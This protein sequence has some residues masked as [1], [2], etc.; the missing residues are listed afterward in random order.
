MPRCSGSA[1]AEHPTVR[2]DH[3]EAVEIGL[4]G[5][6]EIAEWQHDAELGGEPCKIRDKW[7]A[8]EGMGEREEFVDQHQVRSLLLGLPH[9]PFGM[10][11][12]L[13]EIENVAKFFGRD[14]SA[15]RGA[16]RCPW[17]L[18]PMALG[19]LRPT[20]GEVRYKGVSLARLSSSAFRDFRR[21]VQ[22]VFQNPFETFNPFYRVSHALELALRLRGVSPSSA[23]GKA[24]MDEALARVQLDPAQVLHRYSHELS[25]GQ[26]QRI[27]IARAI[28]VSPKLIVADEAVSMVDASLRVLILRYLL[29]LRTSSDVNV[30]YITHDLSTLSTA[31][32]ISDE[33]L[34]ARGGRIVERGRLRR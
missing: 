14:V 15:V 33:L 20:S 28:L 16:R 34:I 31:L 32:Q 6:L 27:S 7:I 23:E 19:F 8:F 25:G 12:P 3:R 4:A 30:L 9:E 1:V 26:L 13:I 29:D 17:R 22:V 10:T 5:A 18:R 21:D 24:R 11:P 2:V